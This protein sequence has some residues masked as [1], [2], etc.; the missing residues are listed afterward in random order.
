SVDDTLAARDGSSVRAVRESLETA[1]ALESLPEVAAAAHAGRLSGEQLDAVTRLADER[2]DREWAR[3]APNIPPADPAR[4]ARTGERPSVEDAARR[5]AGRHRRGGAGMLELRGA[6]SDP[7]GAR[8]EATI[9]AM[10]EQLRPANGERWD[11]FEHRAADVLVDRDRH[12]VVRG[13]RRATLSAK[14]RRAVL[15]R[16]GHCPT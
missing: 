12:A 1:R 15:L 9:Q 14:I 6:L 11:S 13:T 16:D 8:F 5:R 10:V 4:L 7:T 3:R 2:S